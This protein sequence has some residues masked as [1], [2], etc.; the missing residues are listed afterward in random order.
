MSYEL[1][2]VS[3]ALAIAATFEGRRGR[4]PDLTI[5]SYSPG[6]VLGRRFV[7]PGALRRVVQSVPLAVDESGGRP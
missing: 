5:L 7:G 2:T 4:T 1:E 6:Q 3:D